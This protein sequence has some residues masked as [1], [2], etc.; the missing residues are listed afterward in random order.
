MTKKMLLVLCLAAL[1][2]TTVWG[3]NTQT[4]TINGATV[5]KNVTRITFEGDYIVL[6]FADGSSEQSDD[7]ASVK[8]EFSVPSAVRTLNRDNSQQ[9]VLVFD[10]TGKLVATYPTANANQLDALQKGAYIIKKGKQ[11]VKLIKN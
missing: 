9:A 5:E 3:D 4:V 6:H 1:T 10:M 8:I 2:S 7:F 11:T